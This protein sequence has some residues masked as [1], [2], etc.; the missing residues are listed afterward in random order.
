MFPMTNLDLDE[1]AAHY[2][3]EDRLETWEEYDEK[4]LVSFY[5]FIF[6]IYIYFILRNMVKLSP[7]SRYC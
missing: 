2:M 5:F 3:P 1:E 4:V 6:I 7:R